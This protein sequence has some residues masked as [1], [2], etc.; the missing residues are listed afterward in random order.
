MF[1]RTEVILRADMTSS[2]EAGSE[3]AIAL[4]F[5][6]FPFDP[7]ENYPRGEPGRRESQV[8]ADTLGDFTDRDVHDR[9]AQPQPFRQSVTNTNAYIEKNS[10]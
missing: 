8:D 4:L 2:C 7:R 1:Y 9:T 6:L 5:L 10:T 3:D